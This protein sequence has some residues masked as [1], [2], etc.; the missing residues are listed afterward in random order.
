MYVFNVAISCSNHKSFDFVAFCSFYYLPLQHFDWKFFFK[1][2][3]CEKGWFP[4]FSGEK[5]RESPPAA[6]H[7]VKLINQTCLS[8]YQSNIQPK[9]Y[10]SLWA[11]ISSVS[12]S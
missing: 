9:L 6:I 3:K 7:S 4:C 2:L 12:D 11:S 8:Y 5:R 10:V 1:L